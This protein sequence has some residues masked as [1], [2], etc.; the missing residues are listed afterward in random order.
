[1]R[2]LITT[3]AGF[4]HV[5]PVIPLARA[6]V[7]RG[8]DVLWALP[9]DGVERVATTGLRTVG[10]GPAGLTRPADVRASLQRELEGLSPA[11]AGDVIFGRM[12]GAIS[13]PAIL[14]E[15]EPIALDWRPDL[16]VSDAAEFAGHLVAAELGVPSVTKGFGP[17]LPEVRMARA[18]DAVAHLWHERGLEPRPYGG[19]YDHL[20]LDVYPSLLSSEAPHVRRRQPLRPEGEDGPTDAAAALPLPDGRANAPLVYVT[21]GTVFHDSG[22]MA[23]ILDALSD[24]DVRVLATV[25]PAGDPAGLGPRPSHVRVERYVPQTLVL[26]HCD[27]IVSH[28]GSGTVLA[29]ARLGLPQLCLPQG[30]DQFLNAA[31][32]ASFGAGISLHPHEQ[33]AAAISEAVT[34]LLGEVSYRAKA[35]E[36]GAAIEAMPSSAD[37]AA[38]LE[39]L[40]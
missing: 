6:L 38:V 28:A 7:D 12:F 15:L 5:H 18:G 36:V 30:A 27:V 14:A 40:A 20:Y 39:T 1:M 37:V 2:V 8:H 13:T 22:P 35:G 4:G 17:L 11:E 25:G 21:M 23:T 26:A 9:A 33:T 29:T 16:V 31:A 10:A 32:I 34:R 3:P 24:L 19:A